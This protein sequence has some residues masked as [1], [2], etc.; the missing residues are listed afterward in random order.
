MPFNLSGA[1][2]RHLASELREPL[3]GSRLDNLYQLDPGTFLLRL[4]DRQRRRRQ[5]LLPLAGLPHLNPGKFTTPSTPSLA[6]QVLRKHLRDAR[7]TGIEQPGLDRILWLDLERQETSSRLVVELFRQGNLLLVQNGILIWVL[8]PRSYRHRTL[9]V[10]KAYQLPPQGVDPTIM[11]LEELVEVFQSQEGGLE[12]ALA[13][14]LNL[15][16]QPAR[17]VVARCDLEPKVP[18][19]ELGLAQLQ[20]VAGHVLELLDPALTRPHL[21]LDKE[22]DQERA[23]AAYPWASRLH[24]ECEPKPM[25]SLSEAYA[26]LHEA[27]QDQEQEEAPDPEL[28]RWERRMAQ[29][30]RAIGRYRENAQQRREEAETLYANYA[31]AQQMLET[32][33]EAVERMGWEGLIESAGELPGLVRMDPA[34]KEVELR[35]GDRELTLQVEESVEANANRLYRLA[36]RAESKAQGAVEAQAGS[37]KPPPR[38]DGSDKKDGAHAQRTFWFERFRW[39]V[40]SAG[41]IG[42]AGRDAASNE[43]VVRRYLKQ[44]DV[45]CHA[46]LTGAPSVV[47]KHAQ[48]EVSE[49]AAHE[50]CLYSLAYSKAWS[51]RVASGHT[52]WAEADQVSKTPQTG[53]F[54]AKGSFVI[55]GQRHWHRNQAVEAAVGWME[56]EGI[57]RVMG[58]P[59]PA[60]EALSTRYVVLRPGYLVRREVARVLAAGLGAEVGVL[61]RGLPPGDCDLVRS[62]GLE[63]EWP[64]GE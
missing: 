63:V 39:F 11:E 9:R 43:T 28:E 64:K 13:R 48:G 52:Y 2:L 14:G 3:D 16:P 55:R 6:A 30:E 49:K 26:Q 19:D 37:V 41:N 31:Q 17:E 12:L 53:E 51:A 22:G 4:K 5:L 44:N 54:L 45:Y 42:V 59:V 32:L 33:R 46:D 23:V 34:R 60:L 38:A 57:P 47:V 61:E 35:L 56:V 24:P 21:Y 40:T 10:G 7:V 20:T 25:D 58:G 50:G 62:V 15:G 29:Q 27:R 18:V 36:K 1:A 8:K